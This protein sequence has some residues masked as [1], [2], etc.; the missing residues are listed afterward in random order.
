M[1]KNKL[2][3]ITGLI[4]L[5]MGWIFFWPF[6][7][8]L[9][10]L[11][12]ATAPGKGWIDGYSPTSGFIEF[13]TSG[14]FANFYQVLAGAGIVDWLFMAGLLLIGL[15]LILG[16]GVKISSF[17]GVVL[18]VILFMA[19]LPPSKNPLLDEHVIYILVLLGLNF[20]PTGAGNWLGFGKWWR[21]RLFVQKN[22]I[23]E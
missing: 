4:R 19:V 13:G 3:L 20:S 11:G 23:F 1:P 22:P 14:P 7:D 9:Y 6:L 8:K 16:I 2:Q 21:K 5:A 17:L 10:G 18:S 15:A 12:F